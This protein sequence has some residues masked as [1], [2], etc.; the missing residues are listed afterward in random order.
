MSSSAIQVV[1]KSGKIIS[2]LPKRPEFFDTKMTLLFGS[3]GTGKTT[4]LNEIMFLLRASVPNVVVLSPTNASNETFTKKIPKLCIKGWVDAKKN[5]AFLYKV[6]NRQKWTSEVYAKANNMDILASIFDVLR[7]QDPNAVAREREVLAK[8]RARMTSLVTI[9]HIDKSKQE[10]VMREAR[11][12][13]L[14]RIYKNSIRENKIFLQSAKLSIE[15]VT[16]IDNIDLNPKLLLILDDCASKFKV[17]FKKHGALMNEIFYEGRQY[18]MSTIITIQDD[19]AM[20]SE[21]RKNAM[22]S[23]FMTDVIAL[24][25]FQR[26]SNSFSKAGK[27]MAEEAIDAVFAKSADGKKHYRKLVYIRDDPEP[28]KYT[29]AKIYGDFTMGSSFLWEL[30]ADLEKPERDSLRQNPLVQRYIQ[31]HTQEDIPISTDGLIF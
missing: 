8:F 15:Q 26:A 28:F 13:A 2:P 10:Q 12:D 17:W 29:V 24:S 3:T 19:K 1:T 20:E 25:N 23:I 5:V 4:V 7:E 18:H 16:A 21:W 14:R 30:S 11:D 6:M 22:V 31:E 27:K 9:E